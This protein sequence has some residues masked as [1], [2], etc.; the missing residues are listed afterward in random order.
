MILAARG[1]LGRPLGG[2]L[3]RLGGLL[4]RLGII[5]GVLD[6]PLGDPELSWPVLAASWDPLGPFWPIE[7][8]PTE[9]NFVDPPPLPR[10]SHPGPPP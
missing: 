5:F 4:G 3:G 8:R 6:R 10:Q 1:P 7:P 9:P 2:L